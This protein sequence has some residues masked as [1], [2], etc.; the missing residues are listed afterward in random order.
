MQLGQVLQPDCRA[1]TRTSERGGG[2]HLRTQKLPWTQ[3]VLTL[4]LTMRSSSVPWGSF[5]LSYRADN[6]GVPTISVQVSLGI[7]KATPG[8]LFLVAA[9]S[10]LGLVPHSRAE[11]QGR[12][13]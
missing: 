1:S 8:G 12:L 6:S 7:D 5:W 11:G 9:L 4:I 10:A 2:D 3:I 13:V